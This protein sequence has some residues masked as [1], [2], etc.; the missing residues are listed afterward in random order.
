[1]SNLLAVVSAAPCNASPARAIKLGRQDDGSF[2]IP[3]DRLADLQDRV[4]KMN[5]RARRTDVGGLSLV[6]VANLLRPAQGGRV[7]PITIV[8][9]D[10]VVPMVNGY[11][12][13][14]RIEHTQEGNVISK[15]PRH[16]DVELPNYFRSAAPTCDHCNTNRRRNDTFV[17]SNAQGEYRRV[18]RNCLA[19]FVRSDDVGD[20]VRMY[21]LLG[22]VESLLEGGDDDYMGGFGGG[23][24]YMST[25]DFLGKVVAAIRLWGWCARK[26]EDL[27]F[28]KVSTATLA[29]SDRLGKPT[30]ADEDKAEDVYDWAQSLADRE[31]VGDYI[32]NLRTACALG[33]VSSRHQG[34]VAS[35]VV[36]YDRELA[37]KEAAKRTANSNHVGQVGQRLNLSLT[38]TRSYP[39]ETMY[40]VTTI[41]TMCD[42]DGN[43]FK[44]FASGYQDYKVGDKVQGK[45]TVKLHGEWQGV[46]ETTVTR[47]KLDK[48]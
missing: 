5:R 46:K 17:L 28:G 9:V 19:D 44:W 29:L 23:R 34:I 26:D 35:A 20:A 40:G 43:V 22:K 4:A 6:V 48:V 25:L 15:A 41:L 3:S 45:G 1:M 10:G 36:A 33:Y 18:G 30:E 14:A 27:A 39:K 38:V 12:F 24:D 32:H 42:K 21:D 2:N 16:A 8:R 47:C 31:N 7:Q 11:T 37:D 13:I